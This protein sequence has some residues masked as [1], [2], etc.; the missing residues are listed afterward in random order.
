MLIRFDGTK[1]AETAYKRVQL[2]SH[3]TGDARSLTLATPTFGIRKKGDNNLPRG[4][5]NAMR[6]KTDYSVLGVLYAKRGITKR[7]SVLFWPFSRL[8]KHCL[9]CKSRVNAP[10]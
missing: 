2:L 9:A 7:F 10:D 1:N 3:V 8:D 4:R 6:H 5:V